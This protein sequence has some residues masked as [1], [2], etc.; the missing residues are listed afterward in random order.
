MK[1]GPALDHLGSEAV[2]VT[3]AA[4]GDGSAYNYAERIGQ[5]S[6]SFSF[7]FSLPSL[8]CARPFAK[9]EGSKKRRYPRRCCLRP[10]GRRVTVLTGEQVR[11]RRT[12]VV[13][14][15][16]RRSRTNLR[17]TIPLRISVCYRWPKNKDGSKELTRWALLE[18]LGKSASKTR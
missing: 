8:S 18:E 12:G 6:L 1:R 5:V 14:R 7:S 9:F 10:V 2:V 13:V 3:L 11:H 16:R 15:R 17:E 4:F